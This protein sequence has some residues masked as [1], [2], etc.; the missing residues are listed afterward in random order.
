[1]EVSLEYLLHVYITSELNEYVEIFVLL[2]SFALEPI[3]RHTAPPVPQ[4][5]TYAR[6]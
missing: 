4:L 3:R 1:M 2:Q 6:L 5:D